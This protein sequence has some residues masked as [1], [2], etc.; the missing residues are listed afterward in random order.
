MYI[1]TKVLPPGATA[2]EI[3]YIAL[4]GYYTDSG[5]HLDGFY[6]TTRQASEVITYPTFEEAEKHASSLRLQQVIQPSKVLVWSIEDYLEA[7]TMNLLAGDK[8]YY[9]GVDLLTKYTANSTVNSTANST[10]SSQVGHS[11]HTR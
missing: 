4:C 10:V 11:V 1:I 9:H 5:E 3:W 7:A 2:P 8:D 6:I